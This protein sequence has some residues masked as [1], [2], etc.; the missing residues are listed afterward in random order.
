MYQESETIE[1]KREL[2]KNIKKEIVAFANTKGGTIYIGID[3]DGNIIG[4]KNINSDI[5][6][7]SSMIH[8]GI[9]IFKKQFGVM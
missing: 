7:L 4:L 3:D 2:T 1:L 8:D 5:E 9:I 6:A